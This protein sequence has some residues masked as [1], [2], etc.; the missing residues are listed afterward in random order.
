MRVS[1][2]VLRSIGRRI[3]V[4]SLLRIHNPKKLRRRDKNRQ[5]ENGGGAWLF[6]SYDT[7]SYYYTPIYLSPWQQFFWPV[8]NDLILGHYF[9]I[10]YLILTAKIARAYHSIFIEVLIFY[11][12]SVACQEQRVIS[13]RKQQHQ[14]IMSSSLLKAGAALY[15][16][17]L[18][19]FVMMASSTKLDTIL[20]QLWKL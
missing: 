10:I 20:V 18:S 9:F 19:Q 14:H 5:K 1:S 12:R 3:V 13:I 16:I 7:Y 2:M 15:V 8:Y 6:L 11:R 17:V 4:I